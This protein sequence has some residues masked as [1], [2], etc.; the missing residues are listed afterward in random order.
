MDVATG[1]T[2]RVTARVTARLAPASQTDIL[3]GVFGSTFVKTALQ[4]GSSPA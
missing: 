4:L 2:A 1:L 3:A